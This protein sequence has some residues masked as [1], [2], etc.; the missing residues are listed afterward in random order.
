MLAQLVEAK[1][2]QMMVGNI[3][4]PDN[5]ENKPP[6]NSNSA[7]SYGRKRGLPIE[8]RSKMWLKQKEQKLQAQ[9]SHKELREVEGCTFAPTTHRKT[10]SRFAPA[11][12]SFI[13]QGSIDRP[14][15]AS[16]KTKS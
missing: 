8:Q 4:V 2:S 11:R 6:E 3:D 16:K 14:A 1:L 7:L 10:Q 15:T 12:K 9:R 5:V 13:R